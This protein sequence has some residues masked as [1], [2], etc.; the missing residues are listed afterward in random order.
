MAL[1]IPRAGLQLE[2][3]EY[4]HLPTQSFI[5]D[6]SDDV[7]E[8]MIKSVSQGNE[9]RLSLGNKPTFLYGS[10]SYHIEPTFEDETDDIELFLESADTPT[11]AERLPQLAMSLFRKPELGHPWANYRNSSSEDE[12]EEDYELGSSPEEE[13]IEQESDDALNSD[14][15]LLRDSLA[16]REAEKHEKSTRVI[17]CGV[18]AH[19]GK[20]GGKRGASSLQKALIDR[21]SP[22]SRSSVSPRPMSPSLSTCGSPSLLPVDTSSQSAADKAKQAR[23][24]IIH[25]LAFKEQPYEILWQKYPGSSEAEFKSAL[26][27][28]ADLDVET[29]KYIL[30]KKYWRELDVWHH[31]YASGEERQK[32]I[33]NAVRQFDK[34]RLSTTEPEWEKLLPLE[35]RRRG[36]ILSKVQVSIANGPSAPKIRVQKADEASGDSSNG[37]S[38]ELDEGAD[39][40]GH[41]SEI[42]YSTS[43]QTTAA[44]SKKKP[45][46]REAQEKRLL[47]TKKKSPPISSRPRSASPANA[48]KVS[49][50]KSAASRASNTDNV[51]RFKSKE[52]VSEPDS[53]DSDSGSAVKPAS[54]NR[55]SKLAANSSKPTSTSKSKTVAA[56]ATPASRLSKG[57]TTLSTTVTPKVRSPSVKEIA[58]PLLSDKPRQ[59]KRTRD[60]SDDDSGSNSSSETPLSKR[61]KPLKAVAKPPV[62]RDAKEDHRSPQLPSQ[63]P[64]RST[65]ISPN[66]SSS[67]SGGGSTNGGFSKSKDNTSPVKSSPLASSPP[68]NASE[69]DL[70]SEESVAPIGTSSTSRKRK[71]VADHRSGLKVAGATSNGTSSKLKKRRI[72]PEH[73]VDKALRF[74]VYY[75]KYESLYRD[76]ASRIDPP[77]ERVAELLR[78][79]NRLQEMKNNIHHEVTLQ[80]A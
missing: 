66:E 54:A 46:A 26:E 64:A 25:E 41:D 22:F 75:E 27:K 13:D 45:T 30:R 28:V 29:H 79:H 4:G 52:F 49:P 59:K 34:M 9:I 36:K 32:A 3:G 78:M 69:L 24:P 6:L 38:N 2:E 68:T 51:G 20:A 72:L 33:N 12:D 60:Q 55:Q 17:E 50:A 74:K 10:S 1:Q 58:K 15:A 63:P 61:I 19:N 73:L 23:S 65:N 16:Q 37:G 77:R 8:G 43:R 35:E 44:A 67:S 76:I 70:S 80:R 62:F 5:L 42:T 31:E 57:R 40:D 71:I 39:E 21:R 47:S 18:T 11:R 56:K 7:I 14:I 53:S 48:T